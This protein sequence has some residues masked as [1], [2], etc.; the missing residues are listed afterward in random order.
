MYFVRAMKDL[1]MTTER[2]VTI[3]RY[4]DRF[5]PEILAALQ[6]RA[7]AGTLLVEV[8]SPALFTDETGR[9][10]QEAL[11]EYRTV[12]LDRVCGK[13]ASVTIQGDAVMGTVVPVGPNA[14]ML[15]LLFTTPAPCAKL[16]VRGFSRGSSSYGKDFKYTEVC[17]VSLLP[18][19]AP[20]VRN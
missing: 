18:D 16:G 12:S 5:T 14:S 10:T 13:I 3:S 1:I 7:V 20:Y 19:N 15:D 11:R 6:A 9:V 8:G 17:G 4:A 2:A